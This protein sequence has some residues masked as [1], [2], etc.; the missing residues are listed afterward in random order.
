ML[1]HRGDNHNDL[2]ML[3]EVSLGV[4]MGKARPAVLAAASRIAP[5]NTADGVLAVLEEILP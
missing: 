2:E 3:R 5:P 4:A 1:T